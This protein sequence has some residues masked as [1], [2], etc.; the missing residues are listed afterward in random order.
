M[1]GRNNQ[2]IV[3]NKVTKIFGIYDNEK[4]KHQAGSI[5]NSNGLSPTLN[6]MSS[7][8]NQQPYILINEATKKGYTKAKEG[9]SINISYPNSNTK[10]A[11][12]G[13]KI[14][15][16]IL[17]SPNMATVVKFPKPICLN[18]KYIHPSIQDRIYDTEG[19]STIITASNFK[20]KIAERIIYNPYNEKKIKSITPTKTANCEITSSSVA[21]LISVD[22]KYLMKIR[23]LTP[24]E[25]WRL[26]G[27]D[28]EDFYR[29]KSIGISDTQ[30]Y[31][32]AGNSIVVNVLKFIF[33][34]LFADE[35][36]EK[37][38]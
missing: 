8:G 10:R 37:C 38:A 18:N 25:C 24:L 13:K 34:K 23:K 6:T 12:V 30:L 3:D 26:M 27:F 28:D 2:Y 20:P 16:T 29:V 15:Q 19:I 35:L 1:D 17:T 31:K 11:R 22:G 14:S 9:D 7:G 36:L 5:Y 33:Q 21:I 32:M 4:K